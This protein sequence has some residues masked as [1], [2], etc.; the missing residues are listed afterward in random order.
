MEKYVHLGNVILSPDITDDGLKQIQYN[1]GFETY[2]RFQSYGASIT[3]LPHHLTTP[4]SF[5]VLQ[6]LTNQMLLLVK[7]P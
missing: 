2:Y 5:A 4:I 7:V 6:K 3:K 1:A